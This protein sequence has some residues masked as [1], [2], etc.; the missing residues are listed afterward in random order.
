MYYSQL[1]VHM[2][3]HNI[4]VY[5]QYRCTCPIRIDILCLW[6]AGVVCWVWVSFLSPFPL[7][8][9]TCSVPCIHDGT[10]Y[11]YMYLSTPELSASTLAELSSVEKLLSMVDTWAAL[12]PSTPSSVWDKSSPR[13]RRE[14]VLKRRHS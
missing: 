14:S 1:H 13:S 9:C 4:S 10:I 5:V 6:F 2:Y 7:R 8:L 3:I 12:S 11:M